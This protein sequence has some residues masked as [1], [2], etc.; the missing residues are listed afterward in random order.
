MQGKWA[1]SKVDVRAHA[2]GNDE[3]TF[4]RTNE[5]GDTKQETVRCPGRSRYDGLL[6]H[7]NSDWQDVNETSTQNECKTQ[8]DPD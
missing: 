4:V 6:F 3:M 8:S 7:M 5:D 1:K 2:A